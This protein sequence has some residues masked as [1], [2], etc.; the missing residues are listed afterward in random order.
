M[1]VTV[2]KGEGKK[3]APD[4]VDET[5][6]SDNAGRQR[7]EYELEQSVSKIV[8]TAS[9]AAVMHEPG[10]HF[11]VSD[12]AGKWDGLVNFCQRIF[13]LSD[14]GETFTAS[15]AITFHRPVRQENE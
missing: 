1:Q 11:R 4:V 14:D 13:E 9:M 6:C 10:L 7:G 3:Q 12:E 5:L 2:V 15:T 8:E